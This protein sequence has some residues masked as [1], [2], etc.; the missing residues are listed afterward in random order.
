[1]VGK[2]RKTTTS[3]EITLDPK[4]TVKG[5]LTNKNT[6]TKNIR[7]TGWLCCVCE[8]SFRTVGERENHMSEHTRIKPFKCRRCYRRFK[9]KDTMVKHEKTHIVHVCNLCGKECW[10]PND[11]KKHLNSHTGQKPY[12]CNYCEKRFVQVG[13][14]NVHEKKIHNEKKAM[15]EHKRERLSH[16]RTVEQTAGIKPTLDQGEPGK[17]LTRQQKTKIEHSIDQEGSGNF[18]TEVQEAMIEHSVAW[19]VDQ[20]ESSKILSGEQKD[21]IE[22]SD[23]DKPSK[24]LT[25]GQKVVIVDQEESSNVP[26]RGQTSQKHKKESSKVLGRKRQKLIEDFSE[27]DKTGKLEKVK[28][29]LMEG[30]SKIDKSGKVETVK[31]K[32]MEDCS[33]V[34]KTGKVETVKAKPMEDGSEVDKT[35]KVEKVKTKLM[36]SHCGK[37]WRTLGEL[38]HHM[39]EHTG[40]KPYKCRRCYRRFD[41]DQHRLKHEKSHI[42]HLCHTCGAK[43]IT[44][45]HL[46]VHCKIHTGEK[47]YKCNYCKKRFTQISQRNKHEKIHA[48][49]PHMCG[50]CDKMFRCN[51]DLKR[52]TVE[53]HSSVFQCQYCDK[54]FADE[55]HQKLHEKKYTIGESECEPNKQHNLKCE[56]CGK[57]LK[58]AKQLERHMEKHTR[59]V[60]DKDKY[61]CALCGKCYKTA[62]ELRHHSYEH[63]GDNPYKCRRCYRRF[64]KDELRLKHEKSH[65]VH[66][67]DVCGKE[68][69]TPNDLMIHLRRHTGVKPYKCSYCEKTFSQ[70]SGRVVHEKTHTG[71][72][73]LK[74]S[75]CDKRFVFQHAIKLHMRIHHTGEKPFKC[76]LCDKAYASPWSKT[77]HERSHTGKARWQKKNPVICEICGKSFKSLAERQN[78]VYEHTGEKPYKCKR[79]Y[80]RFDEEDVMLAHQRTHSTRVCHICGKKCTSPSHLQLHLN[81][82]MG[83]RPYKCKHCDSSFFTPSMKYIHE[84]NHHNKDKKP[85]ECNYCGKRFLFPS[86]FRAHQRV[87]TG[88][89][90]YKCDLCD[91]QYID[92]KTL[93]VHKRNHQEKRFVC[94]ICGAAFTLAWMLKRHTSKKHEEAETTAQTTLTDHVSVLVDSQTVMVVPVGGETIAIENETVTIDNEV[95]ADVE[96]VVINLSPELN[97][98]D[99]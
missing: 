42:M 18:I 8:K 43:C 76:Q 52:H 44:P 89:K 25:R 21:M 10:T 14:R 3:V 78:H 41:D 94:S 62:A 80:R 38:Q 96:Y 1:M 92:K 99:A 50:L 77:L 15:I 74:C 39:Y 84:S 64:D 81:S 71:E 53:S 11:L 7:Q 31:A 65:K 56:T 45:S 83:L 95:N 54:Q 82:H 20:D 63:T 98:P 72:K 93:N 79:C 73:P 97:F 13:Q 33:K 55:Q 30:R 75:L 32:P 9:D 87:H 27:V 46:K 36:C 70:I 29:N 16:V 88:E 91:K 86:Q 60:S 69:W 34:D 22:H 19:A 49:K 58:T 51:D 90:P 85:H 68:C 35:E 57:I 40:E 6:R 61:I 59:D 66:I 17:I 48:E 2:G 12:H 47:P 23:H 5:T 28:T 4:V 67:C 24:V 37:R 26:T